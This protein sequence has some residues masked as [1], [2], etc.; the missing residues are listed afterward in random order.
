MLTLLGT[1]NITNISIKQF[2]LTDVALESIL[3]MSAKKIANCI[4]NNEYLIT[5]QQEI[6]FNSFKQLA[7]NGKLFPAEKKYYLDKKITSYNS[8]Y[9]FFSDNIFE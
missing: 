3:L 1:C 4:K 8:Y 7:I 6:Y 5:T 2:E 9:D